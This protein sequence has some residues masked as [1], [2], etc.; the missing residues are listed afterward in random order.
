MVNVQCIVILVRARGWRH[1]YR[2][3]RSLSNHVW[4]QAARNL[5][6]RKRHSSK[7]TYEKVGGNGEEAFSDGCIIWDIIDDLRS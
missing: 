4:C 5:L 2:A 1:K 3:S 6:R 7:F